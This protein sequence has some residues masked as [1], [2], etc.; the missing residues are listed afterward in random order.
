MSC[1]LIGIAVS[2]LNYSG[3]CFKENRYLSNE[4]KINSAVLEVIATYPPV[5][6]HEEVYRDEKM[7]IQKLKRV[8]KKPEFPIHYKNIN[9]FFELNPDCCQVTSEARKGYV[10]S[11][12]ERI[13]GAKC[14]FVRLV[15]IV[16]YRS[17]D[18]VEKSKKVT[19]Y[20]AI[21]NCGYP[22]PGMNVVNPE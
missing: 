18:D 5:I 21:S 11:F 9:E 1:V 8:R 2:G 14:G 17:N 3:Y 15:Y 20:I 10:P 7:G 13:L 4:E 6:D 22:W 16:R 19:D 12:E